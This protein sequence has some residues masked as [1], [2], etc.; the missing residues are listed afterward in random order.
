MSTSL[1]SHFSH[2]HFLKEQRN[3]LVEDN[4]DF[5]ASRQLQILTGDLVSFLQF[6]LPDFILLT[7]ISILSTCSILSRI[8]FFMCWDSEMSSARYGGVD[9]GTCENCV[10]IVEGKLALGL[11]DLQI[12]KEDFIMRVDED[13]CFKGGCIQF[14]PRQPLF[15]AVEMTWLPQA[16]E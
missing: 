14:C 16:Q 1:D 13:V 15:I 7:R 5:F 10:T 11:S 3:P 9:M 2:S 6:Q 4:N 8:G 12:I